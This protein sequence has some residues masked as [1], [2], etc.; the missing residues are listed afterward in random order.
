MDAAVTAIAGADYSTARDKALAAQAVLAAFP[1]SNR[2]TVG[3]GS[4]GHSWDRVAISNFIDRCQR[5]TNSAKGIQVSKVAIN[6]VNGMGVSQQL[7]NFQ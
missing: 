1:D 5:L 7:G 2:Q 6:A 4:Q 3:G